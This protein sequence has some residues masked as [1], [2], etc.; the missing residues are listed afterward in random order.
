MRM[1]APETTD[2]FFEFI[3][4]SQFVCVGAKAALSRNNIEVY[5]AR[6]I[7]SAWDDVAISQRL[8]SFAHKYSENS[9]PFR[10]FVVLFE[11]SDD[12]SEADFEDAL[13]DRVQS[14]S[15][16]DAMHGQNYD[17]R[18]SSDPEDPHFSLSFGGEGFF[19][20][21][22]HPR[23]SRAAR[24][25]KYAA[26]AF[27]LHDQ[28]ELLR[29]S[30]QYEK[31]RSS[32]LTRDENFNGSVNPMLARHGEAS[33]ARQYSGRAVGGDWRCPFDPK[34]RKFYDAL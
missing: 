2:E 21:G 12:M 17:A 4:R 5:I 9:E 7:R 32:I 18:V 1:A 16:K 33:E 13:W 29:E 23:A 31:L 26:L 15:N 11:K 27:N 22:L 25:F 30:G 28:F 19:V 3:R 34:Q 24:R 6:D 14:L 10:S 20:V 8:T